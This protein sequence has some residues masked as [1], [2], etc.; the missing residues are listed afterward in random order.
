MLSCTNGTNAGSS[1]ND[2]REGTV[3]VRPK[4]RMRFDASPRAQRLNNV[5]QHVRV[6]ADMPRAEGSKMWRVQYMGRKVGRLLRRTAG[7]DKKEIRYGSQMLTSGTR[8]G[9]V[10]RCLPSWINGKG[11]RWTA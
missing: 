11:R 6:P 3:L 4:S 7:T 1:R 8:N 10:S 2:E 9:Y 5:D